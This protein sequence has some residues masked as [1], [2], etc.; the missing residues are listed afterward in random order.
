MA[1]LG[2][3]PRVLWVF[4]KSASLIYSPILLLIS[5]QGRNCFFCSLIFIF[6]VGSLKIL[7]KFLSPFMAVSEAH[8]AARDGLHWESNL[9]S[10]TFQASTAPTKLLPGPHLWFSPACFLCS[11]ICSFQ[12]ACCQGLSVPHSTGRQTGGHLSLVTV[13]EGRGGVR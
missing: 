8:S 13:R 5:P 7:T 11:Q 12:S 3:R 9:R 10:H 6:I 2:L 4:G 1:A